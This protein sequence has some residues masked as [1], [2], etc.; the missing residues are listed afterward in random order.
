M[1]PGSPW[2]QFSMSAVSTTRPSTDWLSDAGRG[3]PPR[4]CSD[5]SG[6]VSLPRDAP[7]VGISL[8]CPT[9]PAIA[10][11]CRWSE[12]SSSRGGS[13]RPRATQ[14]QIEVRNCHTCRNA[15]GMGPEPYA[16]VRRNGRG[17]GQCLLEPDHLS[18]PFR[19]GSPG[20][21]QPVHQLQTASAL[22]G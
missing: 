10:T 16:S 19:P 20:V 12:Y 18:S 22:V 17:R 11:G 13:T 14:H 6:P 4:A 15:T 1:E 5:G 8:N 21:G 9:P 7:R 2:P 3:K